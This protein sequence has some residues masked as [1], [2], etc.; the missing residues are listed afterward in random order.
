VC[1]H[2]TLHKSRLNLPTLA[3]M[4]KSVDQL[5]GL[6]LRTKGSSLVGYFAEVTHENCLPNRPTI[7][8][9]KVRMVSWRIAIPCS[10]WSPLGVDE[11]ISSG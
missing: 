9:R 4:A 10:A 3:N 1:V 8:S 6:R 5:H 2:N 11:D 7:D